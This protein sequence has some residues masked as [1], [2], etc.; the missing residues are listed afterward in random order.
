M[1]YHHVPYYKMGLFENRRPPKSSDQPLLSY[2]M[3]I[4]GDIPYCIFRQMQ[5]CQ[6]FGELTTSEARA[7]AVSLGIRNSTWACQWEMGCQVLGW[8]SQGKWYPQMYLVMYLRNRV[9]PTATATATLINL[10]LRWSFILE[11]AHFIWDWMI[12]IPKAPCLHRCRICAD[13]LS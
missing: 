4:I 6:T 12:T 3:A 9:I 2:Y 10:L 8:F 11:Q 5:N 7:L 1:V 13:G